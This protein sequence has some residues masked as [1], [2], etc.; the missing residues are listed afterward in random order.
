MHSGTAGGQRPP[1]KAPIDMRAMERGKWAVSHI[2]ALITPA[3]LKWAREQ[4]GYDKTVAAECIGVTSE[5]LDHWEAGTDHPSLAQARKAAQVYRRPLAVFYVSKP[6]L[7]FATPRD[8]R[9]LPGDVPRHFS[10]EFLFLARSLDYRQKWL[11][12]YR[13]DT[14]ESELA[15]VSSGQ[16]RDAAAL[17]RAIRSTL[18]V[19]IFWHRNRR[20]QAEALRYWVAR[21]EEAGVCVRRDPGIELPEARGLALSDPWAPIIWINGKDAVAGQLFTLAHELAH[22]WL[23]QSGVSNLA[24][25]GGEAL[26][27]AARIE[28][29]CNRTAAGLLVAPEAFEGERGRARALSRPDLI[30]HLS[31]RLKVSEEV[32][33]RMLLERR[34]ISSSDYE[35]LH[36]SLAQRWAQ[37]AGRPRREGSPSYFTLRLAYNGRAFTEDV[38]RAYYDDYATATEASDLLDLK[39]NL[40]PRMAQLLQRVGVSGGVR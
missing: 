25:T 7:D 24:L 14:G 22:I 16:D 17:S 1:K 9:R 10:P 23:G 4:A 15:F 11:A 8:F 21:T 30:A 31:D 36:Q 3:V 27:D 39:V 6:P 28:T 38:L 20:T 2:Q 33:A 18:R 37:R 40:F 35:R 5:A 34:S 12:E 19:D 32:I 29:F 13:R 26:G